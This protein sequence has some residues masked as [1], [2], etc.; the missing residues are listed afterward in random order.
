M[1][2]ERL[3]APSFGS[4]CFS[5]WYHS[6]GMSVGYLRV[7]LTDGD[8]NPANERLLWELYGTQSSSSIDWK[9][10]VVPVGELEFPYEYYKIK[11][12]GTIGDGIEDQLLF[13]HI[14][15]LDLI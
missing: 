9:Y 10:A 8:E 6:L 7:K 11:I 5:F 1:I 15:Y 4:V 12:E 3:E 13:G 14:S 2:S